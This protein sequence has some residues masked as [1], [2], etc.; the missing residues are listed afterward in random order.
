MSPIRIVSL[1]IL[2]FLLFAFGVFMQ[3]G[4]FLLP[5]ALFKPSLLLIV[6]ICFLLQY[7]NIRLPEIT[8]FVWALLWAGTS[9][10]VLQLF[11]SDKYY[12]FHKE[13]I[14]TVKE[15]INLAFVCILFGWQ[16]WCGFQINGFMRVLNWINASLV[17]TC[18][19]L[20]LDQWILVPV[21]MW[22]LTLYSPKTKD[23]IHFAVAVY[24]LFITFSAALTAMYYGRE[25]V[26]FA[27]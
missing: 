6:S 26:L 24:V 15:F 4:V 17:F 3:D 23:T 27:L 20:G 2:T 10:F 1:T 12:A 22:G 13:Q 16:I 19:L 8:L 7:K 11:I 25:S 18:L 5:L 9:Q 21:L 14:E